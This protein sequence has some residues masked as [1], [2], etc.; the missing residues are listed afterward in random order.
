MI[1]ATE[2]EDISE[3]P[4]LDELALSYRPTGYNEK[5]RA[6]LR[7][8]EE[9]EIGE[10]SMP[11]TGLDMSAGEE[12]YNSESDS[13]YSESVEEG[14]NGDDDGDGFDVDEENG[15]GYEDSEMEDPEEPLKRTAGRQLHILVNYPD[16]PGSWSFELADSEIVGLTIKETMEKAKG[17]VESNL[18]TQASLRELGG[19]KNHFNYEL[20][21]RLLTWSHPMY[22]GC[23]DLLPSLR[24]AENEFGEHYR[25]CLCHI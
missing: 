10:A 3:C 23:Y 16:A 24:S 13:D 7:E 15:G 6:E 20:E 11:A 9:T 8:T 12:G 21:V 22:H 5:R 19:V 25:L 4:F 2:T 1:I 17:M 14:D 18:A